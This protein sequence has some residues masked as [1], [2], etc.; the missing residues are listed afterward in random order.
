LSIRLPLLSVSTTDA[1]GRGQERCHWARTW[2]TPLGIC[3][4]R[5]AVS[6]TSDEGVDVDVDGKGERTQTCSGRGG[7]RQRPVTM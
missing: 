7:L 2:T 5:G 6:A 1:V 3:D 4:V